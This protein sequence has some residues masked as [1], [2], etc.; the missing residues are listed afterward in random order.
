MISICR[1]EELIIRDMFSGKASK[2]EL[3]IIKRCVVE[4]K[5]GKGI[6]SEVVTC[7]SDL[8]SS[9]ARISEITGV[10]LS[11][12]RVLSRVL[13]G[14]VRSKLERARQMTSGI[15]KATWVYESYLCRHQ[16]HA[17]L[18]GQEFQLK[19]GIRVGIFRRIH[20]GDLVGCGCMTR[21]IIPIHP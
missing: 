13:W 7:G 8:H 10:N 18:D 17:P 3:E 14:L 4:V 20:V 11:A 19:K 9:A 5:K 15:D 21:P 6:Y 12:S 2:S 1:E 16:N